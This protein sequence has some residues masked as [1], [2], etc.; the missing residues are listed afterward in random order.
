MKN[1]FVA[2]AVSSSLIAGA[3]V[4]QVKSEADKTRASQT[5]TAPVTPAERHA[6]LKAMSGP[7]LGTQVWKQA[8]YDVKETRIGEID[9]LVVAHNGQI[10][11]AVIGVGGFLGIGEKS[12]SVPFSALKPMVRDGAMW[13]VLDTTKEAL[14]SAPA[15]DTSKY[16]L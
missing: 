6:A 3:A 7:M 1:V 16:K 13:F 14:K 12:V 4:A 15:F 2:A 10:T 9:N 5:T 8:V 11:D